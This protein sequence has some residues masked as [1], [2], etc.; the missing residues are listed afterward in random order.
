LEAEDF[1]MDPAASWP[2]LQVWFE[3]MQ[4]TFPALNGLTSP[5]AV[6]DLDVVGD[7]SF[8]PNLITASFGW[9]SSEAAA[10]IGP[11]AALR[12]GV[13][14]VDPQ[15]GQRYLPQNG[16]LVDVDKAGGLL[17]GAKKLFGCG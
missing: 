13:G 15:G 16:K 14:L 5:D 9:S 4:D 11:E 6:E 10:R 3:E 7:Y 8:R 12:A 2:Q 17:R 1:S